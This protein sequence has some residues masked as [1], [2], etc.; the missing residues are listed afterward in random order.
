MI[1][2]TRWKGAGFT[3]PFLIGFV[4]LFLVPIG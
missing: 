1:R 2:A 4:F 3:A